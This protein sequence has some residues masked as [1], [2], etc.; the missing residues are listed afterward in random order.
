MS[1]VEWL[2]AE[3]DARGWNR[4]DLARELGVSASAVSRFMGGVTEAPSLHTM[5][6]ISKVFRVPLVDLLAM[7]DTNSSNRAADS[8]EPLDLR[9]AL[10]R[11]DRLSAP[12]R[13]LVIALYERLSRD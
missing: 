1:L 13:Q 12:D 8:P 6:A 9:L 2:T 4:S 7:A 3:M 10:R 11:D 5:Q